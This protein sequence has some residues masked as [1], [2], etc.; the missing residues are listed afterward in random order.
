[1]HAN[2]YYHVD[3]LFDLKVGDVR[4]RFQLAG[5]EGDYYTIVGKFKGGRIVPFTNKANKKILLLAK[6]K[7]TKDEIFHKERRALSKELWFGRLFSFILIM[8]FVISTEKLSFIFENTRL[9]F[10]VV[11]PFKLRSYLKVAACYTFAICA[12]RQSLHYL[13]IF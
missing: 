9:S 1:M 12:L 5:L 13:G 6:G 11:Q 8:F 2:A 7:L 10:L 4:V 3:D